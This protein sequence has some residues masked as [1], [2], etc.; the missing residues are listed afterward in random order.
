MQLKPGTKLQGGKYEIVRTLGQ[1][2]FGITYLA[3]HTLFERKVAIKEFFM[4]D[5][6]NRDMETSHVSV[7][8]VGSKELVDKFK[9]KFIKEAKT[10]FELDYPHIVRVTDVF[11][12]NGTAYY[13]MENLPGGSLADKVKKEGPLSEAQAER[14]IRQVADALAYIHERNTVHLDVKPSNILLNAKGEA[15]LID[16]GISKH[17]DN[18]GEQTSST[19]VGISKGY[20]PMEQGRDGDVSQ[21]GPSTDIYALGATLY[22]LVSG[23]VPPDASIVVEEGLD[24]PQ[25]VSDRI[26]L[27]IDKAMQ[28]K[29]KDRPQCIAEFL[30]L[31]DAPPEKVDDDETV[32]I[33]KKEPIKKPNIDKHDDD[34]KKPSK[35]WLWTVLGVFAVAVI[36]LAIVYGK[37]RPAEDVPSAPVKDIVETD[38]TPEP[39]KQLEISIIKVTGVKLS[40]TSLELEEGQSTTLKATVTPAN[41]TDKTVTWK[42]YDEQIATVTK[43]G[44]VTTKK[45]G[46]TTIV[47]RCGE[48]EVSCKVTVKEKPTIIKVTEIKISKSM[49]EL[50]VGDTKMLS[51]SVI[52]NNAPEQTVVWESSNYLVVSVSQ[53]GMVSAEKAG[54]AT[55][56]ARCGD[57]KASCNV[58]VKE[59]PKPKPTKGYDNGH[60]WVDLGLPSGTKWA[61]CNVGASSPSDYGNYYAWGETSTKKEYSLGTLKYHVVVKGKDKGKDKDKGKYGLFSKY[62]PSDKSDYWPGSDN[63]D[64]KT[65]LD[66]SDDAA[67]TNWGGKWRTPTKS[68]WEELKAMC[69]WS[70]TWRGCKITGPNG[71][72]IALPAAGFRGDKDVLNEGFSGTYWSSSLNTDYPQSAYCT[73]FNSGGFIDNDDDWREMGNSIRPV[74]E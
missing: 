39:V 15:V 42:S 53:S 31:F 28:P 47:A 5:C 52:P 38:V 10:I 13:V 14:Y 25:G 41:A 6:C 20:A 59:K 8:S 18:A 1:G 61:T 66:L 30:K 44:K 19:P 37:K 11:E 4:K 27:V 62:V 21:F 54:S 48:Q 56:V 9:K 71:Q 23:Q 36:V 63:P 33:T 12:E 24:R 73:C 40:K 60:E 26:W 32:V 49:L 65:R 46:T 69:T 67:H 2:G 35:T 22:H 57:V 58:T 72:S 29:R 34:E 51:C 68:Q 17:Y 74:T 64:N 3:V 55:I 43:A 70:W 16:F 50:E 7:P 45:V